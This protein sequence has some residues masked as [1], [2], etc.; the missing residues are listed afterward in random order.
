MTIT[1]LM[2]Q[3]APYP[4]DLA[5]LIARLAYRP[6]WTFHL[7][8]M[9]RDPADT[10]GESAGGLTLRIYVPCQDSYHPERL[11]PVNHFFIVP[12]ATYDRRAWQR[13][14]LDQILLVEQHEACEWFRVAE[15]VGAGRADRDVR[16]F[17]PNHGPGRNPYTITELGTDQDA[18]TSFKGEV[19]GAE[20][21]A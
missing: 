10:H 3:R 14:L 11:R 5:E 6:G 12:A 18:A 9:E 19:K 7:A 17:A 20:T 2:E 16:P 4:E 8:S 21:D 13:W 1:R 15:T